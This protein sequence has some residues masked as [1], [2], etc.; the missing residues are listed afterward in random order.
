M[1]FGQTYR[2][3]AIILIMAVVGFLATTALVRK[4]G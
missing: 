1:I 4:Y 2:Q 3:M